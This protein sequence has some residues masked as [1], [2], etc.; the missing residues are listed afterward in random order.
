MEQSGIKEILRALQLHSEHIDKK[1]E[2]RMNEMKEHMGN[3][4]DQMEV[5]LEN[6]MDQLENR[7][8]QME[9]KF[10]D[11]FDRL[12]KKFGGLNVELI[13]TQETVDYLAS[14]NVQHE[15]KLRNLT[16]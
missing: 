12:E 13:E 11:R 7:M 2:S 16:L 3:R 1:M 6:R 9:A 5:K 10:D 4:M 8:D 15:R 14:K